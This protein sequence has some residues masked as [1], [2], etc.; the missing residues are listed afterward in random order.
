MLASFFIIETCTV[1]KIVV[2]AL[3]IPLFFNNQLDYEKQLEKIEVRIR[4]LCTIL[5]SKENDADEW[6]IAWREHGLINRKQQG[7]S[8]SRLEK[9]QLKSSMQKLTQKYPKL[10]I[11]SG[12]VLST[13]LINPNNTKGIIKTKKIAD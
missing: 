7:Q 11:I 5:N 6:I 1:P 8:I 4:K 12:T 2:I 9:N 3:K 10:K 13:R